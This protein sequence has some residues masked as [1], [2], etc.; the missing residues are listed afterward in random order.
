MMR[1][2]WI[3]AMS[4]A[5]LTALCG[6]VANAATETL[7]TVYVDADKDQKQTLGGLAYQTQDFGLLGQKDTMDTPFTSV[8]VSRN[9]I[10]N[11]A[12]PT[13]G[14][15]DALS[16]NPSV[17]QVGGDIANEVS[18][19]GFKVSGHSMYI[20]GIPGLLDQQKQTD[21]YVDSVNVISGPNIGLTGTSSNQAVSGTIDFQSKKAMEKPNADLTLSYRGGSSFRQMIDVG[22][23]FG[24]NQRWGIRVTADNIDGETAVSGETL[25]QRDFFINIDQRTTYSKTN[26]LAGYNYNKQE[27]MDSY[28]VSF[29]DGLTH[30]PELDGSN[31][32]MPD[33]AFNEY[34]NW[35]V[36][37]NH[38]Q[39]LND[40]VTAF[41]NAGYHR[42]DWYGY[43]DGS[44]KI[45]NDQ[46]DYSY[47]AD[48][49]PLGVTKKY[50]GLGIKGHFKL[51]ASDH[52]YTVNLDRNWKT[53]FGG[54]WEDAFG[55]GQNEYKI[56]GNLS[57]P[58]SGVRPAINP[59]A[60]P[61]P[62][63]QVM[64]INGWNITDT[65]SFNEGKFQFI[66]GLHGQTL[67]QHS[68]G[69]KEAEYDDVSPTWAFLY[70]PAENFMAYFSL[71]TSGKTHRLSV[72]TTSSSPLCEME[73]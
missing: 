31:S 45:L 42:E 23:R 58:T 43:L 39:K 60:A 62:K 73:V 10:D 5:I 33:W 70:K 2:E 17:R 63:S 8:S 21:V 46:G 13:N 72:G 50:V 56:T 32:Y 12:S 64:T 53:S 34:D 26:F 47:T 6:G 49:Y 59:Y 40:H 51:G 37:F 65:V 29:A 4:A 35:L 19:R 61:S 54:E 36:A 18:I 52:D 68:I 55:P 14:V 1:K 69:G 22:K 9:A 66:G 7:S 11:F 48:V 3:M 16:L 25:T 20:N 71:Q 67:K 57:N 28:G 30:L 38:D 24:D 44:L 41:V 15:M 27:G